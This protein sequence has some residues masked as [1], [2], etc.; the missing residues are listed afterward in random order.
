MCIGANDVVESQ[1]ILLKLRTN[2]TLTSEEIETLKNLNLNYDQLKLA[3]LV[4]E[5]ENVS[6]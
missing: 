6:S 4:K 3:G 1:R 5:K 2:Q